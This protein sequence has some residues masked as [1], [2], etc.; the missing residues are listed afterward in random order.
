MCFFVVRIVSFFQLL[1]GYERFCVL[2]EAVDG[3]G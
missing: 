3:I 1:R 2:K